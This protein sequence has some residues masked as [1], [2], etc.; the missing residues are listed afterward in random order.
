MS[1]SPPPLTPRH[2]IRGFTLIELL[3]TLVILG[4]LIAVAVPSFSDIRRNS[5]LSGAANNFLSA[6]N[7][8]RAEGM[9]RN[10]HAIVTPIDGDNDWS[11]GWVVFVDVD[12]GGTFS[13][14]DLMVFQAAAPPSYI[15]ISAGS[16]TGTA[17]ENPSYLLFDGSGFAKTKAGAFG[18]NT[19]QI[20]RNDVASTQY[21]EIRRVKIAKTGR[22]RI[23]TP[24]SA[25]DNACKDSGDEG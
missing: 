10:M 14:G 18:A 20:S 2:L 15:S 17:A 24:Q 6:L 9:K 4:V 21:R 13:T 7:A 1:H 16:G 3:I 19:V 8:A 12:R 5:E 25:S 23:C 11:K 22:V